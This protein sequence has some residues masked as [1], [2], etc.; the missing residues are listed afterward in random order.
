M[1]DGYMINHSAYTYLM[2]PED[3]LIAIYPAKD[4][5]MDIVNDIK[6]RAL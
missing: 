6:G 1:M 3:E 5:A 2:D 4:T